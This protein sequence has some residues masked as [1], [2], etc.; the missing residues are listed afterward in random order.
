M[1]FLPVNLDD[2]MCSP[3]NRFIT[4]IMVSSLFHW[5]YNSL[6]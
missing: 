5:P 2:V 4:E 6:E 3:N 1:R